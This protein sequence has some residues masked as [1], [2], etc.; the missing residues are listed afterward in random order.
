[1]KCD[2][3]FFGCAQK[4]FWKNVKNEVVET[5]G[6]DVKLLQ[7]ILAGNIYNGGSSHNTELIHL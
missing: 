4:Q 6:Y 5:L 2:T 7:C 1:M 3:E